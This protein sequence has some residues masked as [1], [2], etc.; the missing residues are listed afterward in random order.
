M[1]EMDHQQAFWV[2]RLRILH[3]AGGGMKHRHTT[4]M[5]RIQHTL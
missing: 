2:R 5:L 3:P 4:G 1:L